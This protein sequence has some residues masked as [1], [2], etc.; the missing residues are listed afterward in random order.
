MQ[1]NIVPLGDYSGKKLDLSPIIWV[2]ILYFSIFS[3]KNGTVYVRL[4]I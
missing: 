4:S 3:L 2:Y 1:N